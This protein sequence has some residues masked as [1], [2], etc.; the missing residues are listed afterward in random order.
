MPKN[1]ESIQ[2]GL[3]EKNVQNNIQTVSV[4]DISKI[5]ENLIASLEMDF[6]R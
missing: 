3:T 2:F 4:D 6:E 1:V 5:D